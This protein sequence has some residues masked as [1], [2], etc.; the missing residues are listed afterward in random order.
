MLRFRFKGMIRPGM[1]LSYDD[2]KRVLD[3]KSIW[4]VEYLR[5]RRDAVDY[6]LPR[7]RREAARRSLSFFRK[8]HFEESN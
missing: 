5:S 8:Q 3:R 1:A 6:S 2:A 4:V 7:F